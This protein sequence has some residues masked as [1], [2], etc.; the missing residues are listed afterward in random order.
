MLIIIPLFCGFAL[1]GMGV[2]GSNLR[3]FHT[4]ENAFLSV[5]FLTMG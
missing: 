1:I 4:F 3:E 2:W 5:L